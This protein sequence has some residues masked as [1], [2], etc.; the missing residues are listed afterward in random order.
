MRAQEK[1][2]NSGVTLVPS[3]WNTT[4]TKKE[5][6]TK[7]EAKVLMDQEKATKEKNKDQLQLEPLNF[8]RVL[9]GLKT[10]NNSELLDFAIV[11]EYLTK[12]MEI[13]NVR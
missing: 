7:E 10:K 9:A 11:K 3:A 6:L 2:E 8:M 12:V 4:R 1:Y 13:L 5:G